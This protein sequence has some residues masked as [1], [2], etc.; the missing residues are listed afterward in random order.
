MMMIVMTMMIINDNCKGGDY[1]EDE[2]QMIAKVTYI[3]G[4]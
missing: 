2:N 3:L 4:N 1:D